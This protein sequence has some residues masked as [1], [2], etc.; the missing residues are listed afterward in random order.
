MKLCPF[1]ERYVNVSKQQYISEDKI[2]EESRCTICRKTIVVNHY[3]K[4]KY[5]YIYENEPYQPSKYKKGMSEKDY[6][7]AMRRDEVT[8]RK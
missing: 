3:P 7:M 8:I 4:D 2:I 6:L 5:H 1:C